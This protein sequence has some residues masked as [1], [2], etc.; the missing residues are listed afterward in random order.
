M[1]LQP[2]SI[3]MEEITDPEENARFQVRWAQAERNSDWLQAHASEI[4]RDYRGKYIVVAGQELF[5]ADTVQEAVAQAKAAYPE[6]KGSFTRYIPLK[7]TAR[8][9]AHWRPLVFGR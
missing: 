6:D 1:P 4:Y 7:K 5:A 8:V 9:Y 3:V 2:S